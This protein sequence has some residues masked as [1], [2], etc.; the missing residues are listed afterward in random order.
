MP[1]EMETMTTCTEIANEDIRWISKAPRTAK[2]HAE[3]MQMWLDSIES[4]TIKTMAQ[5]VF[6]TEEN[7]ITEKDLQAALKIYKENGVI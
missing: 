7:K 1:E 4:K 2:A 3:I 5:M 6:W